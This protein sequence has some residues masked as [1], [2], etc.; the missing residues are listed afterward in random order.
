MSTSVTLRNISEQPQTLQKGPVVGRFQAAN[1]VPLKLALRTTN[2]NNNNDNIPSQLS[3][4]QIEKLF[5]KLNLSGT[6]E[7]DEM[8]RLWLKE[9]FIRFHHIFTL[10]DLELGKTDMVKHVIGL[11]DP[12]PF[13]E[14]YQWI[15]PC[16]YDEVNKHLKE[17]LEIREIQ[18]SQSPWASA[19]ILVRKKDDAI[20]F[21]ID[22]HKL[23]ANTIKD[24][25]TLPQMED[26]L[27]SLNGAMMFPSLDLKSGYWQVEL[28][29]DFLY[30][31]HCWTIGILQVSPYAFWPHQ[32]P[33]NVPTFN[34][35]L[36]G[37]P[38]SKLV[39]NLFRQY[40]HLFKNSGRTPEEIESCPKNI[41]KAGLKLKPNKYEFLKSEIMYLGHVVSNKVIATDPKKIRAIQQWPRPTEGL[42]CRV[43]VCVCV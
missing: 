23:N 17:M 5:L 16:Q 37:E 28:D 38:I 36:F 9:L 11:N 21:C 19:I 6:N 24:A 13:R 12:A 33:G 18:K 40:H 27:D 32:H 26:S 2:T 1:L 14:R 25:Q 34:G 41:S 39:Y 29:K 4:E 8:D 22:L 43:C 15:P 42:S 35:K 3:P 20:H 30:S 7:W 10:E 31:L